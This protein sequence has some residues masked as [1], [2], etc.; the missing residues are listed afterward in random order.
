MGWLPFTPDQASSFA[1]QVDLL[2]GVL[3]GLSALFAIP[4]ALV[5]VY[6]VVKYRRG[7]RA[8]RAGFN[9]PSTPFELAWTF[10]PALMA[11]GVFTWGATVYFQIERPPADAIEIDVVGKQ[12]MWKFQHPEGQR[13]ID[14]LHVPLGRSVKLVMT[15][16]DV[17][18][19]LYVP[20]FRIKQDVLPGRYTAIWFRP[21]QVGEYH[22]FCAEYCGT[23][24][25][26]MG[27]RVIVMDP[28]AYQAWLAGGNTAA[29]PQS[30]ETM[31]ASG[32]QLFT[33][34]GCSGCH[35]MDGSG[36]GPSLAGVFG[37]PVPL[38]GGQTATADEGYIR[39]SIL[40]PQSQVVA[41]YQPLMPSFKGQVSEEQILQLIA[42]IKSL[43]SSASQ[44]GRQP[45]TGAQPAPP[46]GQGA[47][48]AS[49]SAQPQPSQ[50]P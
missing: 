10:I 35:H 36:V 38:Q 41:G 20:A 30:P 1:G 21:T 32:E 3:I 14:E 48:G 23:D 18:H 46:G 15:S 13:E 12:W 6:F 40:L 33:S 11:L 49:P 2:Y 47:P 37:K 17:I 42:Y 34:L 26:T 9:P 39:N 31:A 28:A 45:G 29:G 4:I 24:H 19:S 50:A 22:L 8:S 25:A 27:G 44:P 16:E 7:S 5:I 43:G